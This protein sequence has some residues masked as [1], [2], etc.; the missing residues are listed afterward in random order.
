MGLADG[1]EDGTGVGAATGTGVGSAVGFNVGLSVSFCV[2]KPVG[3]FDGGSDGASTLKRPN[4]YFLNFTK[5]SDPWPDA[6]SHPTV[7]LKPCGQQMEEL[8]VQLF[9]PTV[10]SFENT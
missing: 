5:S 10:T 8:D 7:A 4:M 3:A 6:G 2:G 1:T 9:F